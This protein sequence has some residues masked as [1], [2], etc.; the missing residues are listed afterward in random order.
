MLHSLRI[1]IDGDYFAAFAHQ[2][3]QVPSETCA[4]IQHAHRRGDVSAQNLIEQV[5]VDL[6]ELLLKCQLRRILPVKI[7]EPLISFLPFQGDNSGDRK[8]QK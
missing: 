5:N 2:V 8:K 1:R 3:N 4:G 6:A 7:L